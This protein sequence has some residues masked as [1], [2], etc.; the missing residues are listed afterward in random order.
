MRRHYL[1]AFEKFPAIL[2]A[3]FLNSYKSLPR[4]L[5]FCGSRSPI[6]YIIT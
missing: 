5:T 1:Q 3:Y 6:L 2:V 4:L